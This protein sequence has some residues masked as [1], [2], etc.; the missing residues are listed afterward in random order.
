MK[1]WTH[2]IIFCLTSFI[3]FNIARIS[4]TYMYYELDPVGFIEMLCENKEQPELECQGKCQLKKISQASSDDKEPAR[5]IN[6]DE[7]LFFTQ[8]PCSFKLKP[9]DFAI[10]KSQTSYVNHYRFRFNITVFHPPQV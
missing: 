7:L 8:A 2:I 9:R 3:L 10:K 5:I 6:F 1:N 4:F